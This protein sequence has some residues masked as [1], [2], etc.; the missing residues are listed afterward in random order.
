MN[1][2]TTSQT[3]FVNVFDLAHQILDKR[4]PGFSGL[5][6]L[7]KGHTSIVFIYQFERSIRVIRLTTQGSHA[8]YKDHWAGQ[9]LS[10]QGIPV[11]QIFEIGKWKGFNYALSNYYQG[12]NL[13][14]QELQKA[15][16]TLFEQLTYLHRCTLPLDSIE[17]NQTLK[18]AKDWKSIAKFYAQTAIHKRKQIS[19]INTSLES[20]FHEIELQ[21]QRHH[22]VLPD[23]LPL[24][25]VHLDIGVGNILFKDTQITALLDWSYSIAGDFFC[26]LSSLLL[27]N[28]LP[29]PISA[30]KLFFSLY[31]RAGF[32]LNHAE[33]RFQVGLALTA[34]NY[35]PYSLLNRENDQVHRIWQSYQLLSAG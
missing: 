24:Y 10:K 4:Q 32:D 27:K 28:E 5:K 31:G 16:P 35:L 19:S 1:E 2:S 18:K 13:R 6:R 15:L 34:L 26:D 17:T 12:K 21:F 14:Y 30:K 20:V 25:L 23:N 7:A 33:S 22:S 11:P 29:D 8:Y 9:F 3:R